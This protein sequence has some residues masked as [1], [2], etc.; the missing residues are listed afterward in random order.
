MT[1][2]LQLMSDSR[3]S[4]LVINDHLLINQAGGSHSSDSRKIEK[5][6]AIIQEVP[7]RLSSSSR[8]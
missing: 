6:A 7:S 3:K 4:S 5:M 8:D 2:T 1:V